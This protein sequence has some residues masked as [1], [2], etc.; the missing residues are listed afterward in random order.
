MHYLHIYIS[1]ALIMINKS[2]NTMKSVLNETIH[3]V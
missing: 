1:I 3:N 2:V